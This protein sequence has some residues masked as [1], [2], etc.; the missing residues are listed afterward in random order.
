MKSIGGRKSRLVALV[1]LVAGLAPLC[2]LADNIYV[3]NFGL[4]T[5]YVIDEVLTSETTQLA[6]SVRPDFGCVFV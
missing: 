2:V 3:S 5:V 6:L 4:G 1:G